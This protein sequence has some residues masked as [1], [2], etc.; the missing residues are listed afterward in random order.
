MRQVRRLDLAADGVL[1]QNF[2]GQSPYLIDYERGRLFL[3]DEAIVE[4]DRL[5]IEVFG[6][7][8]RGRTVLP[9][10]LDSSGRAW[11]LTLD[12]GATNL[13]VSCSERCPGLRDIQ[14]DS[15]LATHVG[16]RPVSRGMLKQ[17][18]IGGVVMPLGEAVLL[19]APAPDTGWDGVLPTRWFSAIY[20]NNTVVRLALGR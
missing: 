16:E 17:V 7:K 14:K 12:S 11:R 1:G 18:E 5:P 13:V 6:V 9:V 20:V 3:G 8:L 10:K 4:A 19:H 15:L 2:L